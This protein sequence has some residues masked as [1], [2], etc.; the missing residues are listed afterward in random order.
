V[1]DSDQ[2]ERDLRG[3]SDRGR[4]LDER[5]HERLDTPVHDHSPATSARAGTRRTTPGVRSHIPSSV[6]REEAIEL[7]SDDSTVERLSRRARFVFQEERQAKS[8]PVAELGVLDLFA[9]RPVR[10][11]GTYKGAPNRIAF[12]PHRWGEALVYLAAESRLELAHLRLRD[13]DSATLAMLTQPMVIVWPVGDRAIHHV[14]DLIVS[15]KGGYDLVNVKPDDPRF[16]T[17]MTLR[18]HE[19][20][21][22]TVSRLGW[23]TDLA[24]SLSDQAL[25]N[26]R[27]ISQWRWHDPRYDRPLTRIRQVRPAS[28][29]SIVD[30][31]G[32]V[33]FGTE[34]AL[35]LLAHDVDTDLDHPLMAGT[36][37]TWREPTGV[38]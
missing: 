34:L 20:T 31:A 4:Q 15:R 21:T 37:V 18:I 3:L 17:P 5:I 13:F 22:R 1:T 29:G 10:R 36:G 27:A 9:L 25:S 2:P 16:R 28:L 23:D 33:G 8:M 38:T 19:L 7:L 30:I 26:L 14:P 24:G 32:D 12:H 6:T 11:I 35:H